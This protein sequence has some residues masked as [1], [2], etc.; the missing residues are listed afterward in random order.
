HVDS[1]VFAQRFR[2]VAN[3]WKAFENA[4]RRG[5]A[6][7]TGSRCRMPAAQGAQGREAR[8]ALSIAVV[9]LGERGAEMCWHAK[10]KANPMPAWKTPITSTTWASPMFWVG[11]EGDS[12]AGIARFCRQTATGREAGVAYPNEI[13]DL[14]L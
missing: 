13:N 9:A 2:G 5:A 12:G 8:G 3:R 4:I 1:A 7:G 6:T 11:L 14:R 10:T